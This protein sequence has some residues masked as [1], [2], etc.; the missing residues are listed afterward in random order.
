MS[1]KHKFLLGEEKKM[2]DTEVSKLSIII[3]MFL[4]WCT[5]YRCTSSYA[6]SVV[7]VK[8]NCSQISVRR[9]RRLLLLYSDQTLSLS[10]QFLSRI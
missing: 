9:R 10:L 3:R 8:L 7:L 4:H 2:S 6:S 1:P 5:S